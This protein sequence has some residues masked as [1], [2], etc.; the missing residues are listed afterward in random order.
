MIVVDRWRMRSNR[1]ALTLAADEA[2]KAGWATAV[3]VESVPTRIYALPVSRI[4]KARQ[5]HR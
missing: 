5:F 4:D 2:G 3:L 1:H